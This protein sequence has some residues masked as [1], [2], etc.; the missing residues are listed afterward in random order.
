[1]SDRNKRVDLT[2]LGGETSDYRRRIGFS[3]LPRNGTDYLTRLVAIHKQHLDAALGSNEISTR[4]EGPAR[5][6]MQGAEADVYEA[7]CRRYGV[8]DAVMLII[9]RAFDIHSG[10][11]DA[12]V[13]DGVQPFSIFL[14]MLERGLD[15]QE[16]HFQRH[17]LPFA[18]ASE[19]QV[20]VSQIQQWRRNY[21]LSF[22]QSGSKQ[23]IKPS[24]ESVLVMDAAKELSEQLSTG[25]SLAAR[26][27]LGALLAYFENFP[28]R[29]VPGLEKTTIDL[30]KVRSALVARFIQIAG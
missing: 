5:V 3:E 13:K 4:D 7:F 16:K 20:N 17:S 27:L 30:T 12:G 23:A 10:Y 29:E 8:S 6:R 11:A 25:E 14:A 28:G 26:H 24:R 9:G 2:L 19:L 21:Y 15:D 1:L 22:Q 18:L